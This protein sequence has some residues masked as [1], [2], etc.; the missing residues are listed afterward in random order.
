MSRNI[1]KH[2]G[3]YSLIYPE[4]EQRQKEL[5][6]AHLQFVEE[7]DKAFLETWP[8]NDDQNGSSQ[9]EE[10]E[11]KDKAL[12]LIN[13]VGKMSLKE[14]NQQLLDFSYETSTYLIILFWSQACVQNAQD[15]VATWLKFFQELFVKYMDGNVKTMNPHDP[16]QL[17]PTVTQPGYPL[18]WRNRIVEETGDRYKV[19]PVATPEAKDEMAASIVELQKKKM[20]EQQNRR[21]RWKGI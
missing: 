2:T 15:L 21:Q 12:A 14:R 13:E 5:E 8:Q 17:L 18:E 10:E 20:N 4:I 1:H 16:A 9:L 7:T 6:A 19:P 3:R 11:Q